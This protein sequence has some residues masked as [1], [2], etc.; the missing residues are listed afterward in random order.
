[1]NADHIKHLELLQG[2]ISRM[3]GN[4]FL[5]RGWSVTLVSALFAL[6]ANGSD[7]S[8]VV[9]S[10]FPCVIFWLLDAYYLSQERKFRS[11]YNSVRLAE[12]TTFD[13]ETKN[14]AAAR[15]SWACS[16]LSPTLALFHGTIIA[17][18]SIVMTVLRPQ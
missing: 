11:L 6:A 8:F 17:V 18:V 12:S 15:D 14:T 13:M 16:F 4:S 10:Y 7:R 9:V 3:A 1:M 5:I 2:I